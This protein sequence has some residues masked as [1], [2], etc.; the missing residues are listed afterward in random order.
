MNNYAAGQW[1]Y[2]GDSSYGDYGGKGKGHGKS[3]KPGKSGNN[4]GKKP[5]QQETDKMLKKIGILEAQLKSAKDREQAALTKGK[6]ALDR[7]ATLTTATGSE[8][9]DGGELKCPKCGCGHHNQDKYRC[10]IKGCRAILRPSELPVPKSCL[11]KPEPRNPLLSQH[12]QS[13]FL[14]MGA[15]EL[16]EQRLTPAPTKVTTE[17]PAEPKESKEADGD[18]IMDTG[19]DARSQAQEKLE[20]MRAWNLDPSVIAAQEKI[21]AEMPRPRQVRATQPILDLGRLHTALSQTTEHHLKIAK[22]NQDVVDACMQVMNA[23]REALEKAQKE[24]AAHKDKADRQIDELRKLISIKQSE[25]PEELKPTDAAAPETKVA[26]DP[27][28]ELLMVDFHNWIAKAQCPGHLLAL[29][30][31]SDIRPRGGKWTPMGINGQDVPT[32]DGTF[33]AN[34]T[35]QQAWEAA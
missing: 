17:E 7:A 8:A 29:I 19:D 32:P 25:N 30:E 11:V 22:A 9:D 2:I 18:T 13:I 26:E 23:A 33:D 14:A 28:A 27:A 20:Q 35:M 12:Y 15:Q 1:V 34:T 16:L 5:Q 6:Q 21:I 3:G 4:P 10:R 24:Q 31:G